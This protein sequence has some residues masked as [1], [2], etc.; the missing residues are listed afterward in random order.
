MYR[1]IRHNNIDIKMVALLICQSITTSNNFREV[2]VAN[3]DKMKIQYEE[4]TKHV[5][6]SLS[7]VTG[8][9]NNKKDNCQHN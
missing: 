5:V 3:N 6:N 1:L 7:V 4:C 2:L 9:N 8:D